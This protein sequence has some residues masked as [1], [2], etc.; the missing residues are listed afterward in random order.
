MQQK[1]MQKNIVSRGLNYILRFCY[2]QRE[3][4]NAAVMYKSYA[5]L[6]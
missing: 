5:K 3:P 4:E 2:I 1:L 6:Y